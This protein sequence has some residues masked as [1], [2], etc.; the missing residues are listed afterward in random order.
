MFDLSRIPGYG[1]VYLEYGVDHQILQVDVHTD[2]EVEPGG[3]QADRLVD[4]VNRKPVKIKNIV[5]WGNYYIKCRSLI[6][7]LEI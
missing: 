1:G 2:R 3:V 7:V 4:I 6:N 5:T